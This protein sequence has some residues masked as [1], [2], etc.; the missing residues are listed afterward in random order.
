MGSPLVLDHSLPCC[1]LQPA[2]NPL[3]LLK[4]LFAEFTIFLRSSSLVPPEHFNLVGQPDCLMSI[5]GV[6]LPPDSALNST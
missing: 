6:P 4:M 1:R 5:Y 3:P 2:A